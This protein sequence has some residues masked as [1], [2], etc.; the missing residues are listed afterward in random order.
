[1]PEQ[2]VDEQLIIDYLLGALLESEAERL[3]EMSV[4]DDDF[5]ER[6][7]AVENDLVD[8]YVRGELSGNKF[9]SFKSHYLASPKRR[10]KVA[11]AETFLSIV[12]K[13]V[14]AQAEESRMKTFSVKSSTAFQWG[15]AAAAVVILVAVG[16]LLFENVR[17]GNQMA[18]TLADYSELKQ[19]EQEL[20]R[21]LASQRFSD[22]E[23]EKEL[24]RVRDRLAE[25]EQQLSVRQTDLGQRDVKVI[26]FNLSP[27]TRGVSK[28]PVLTVLPGTDYVA[29]TLEVE[30]NDFSAYEV[31][32]KNSA[33]GNVLWRSDKLKAGRKIQIRLPVSLLKTKNHV[34]E[35][36]GISAN[37]LTEILSSY[38]F[39]V[40]SQ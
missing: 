16:Y 20:R 14:S 23:K 1:V 22:T 31:E 12:D 27:P 15:F 2:P 18:R 24:S 13:N 6:L 36:S 25:L 19:R 21:Q 30:A 4:A 17:L 39:Q 32:L 28:I 5:A 11:F 26:A 7:H 3:D 10:K 37:G 33:T 9:E 35:V 38:P 29:I 40:E 34:L 8:A